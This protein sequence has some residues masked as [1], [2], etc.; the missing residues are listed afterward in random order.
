MYF[1][2]WVPKIECQSDFGFVPGDLQISLI[3]S[4]I[5]PDSERLVDYIPEQG[6]RDVEFHNIH[7]CI[8]IIGPPEPEVR[9][10]YYGPLRFTRNRE[11]RVIPRLQFNFID[12]NVPGKGDLRCFICAGTPDLIIG[13]ELSEDLPPM[14]MG[15]A[16]GN[17]EVGVFVMGSHHGKRTGSWFYGLLRKGANAQNKKAGEVKQFHDQSFKTKLRILVPF[18]TL[19][20]DPTRIR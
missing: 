16:V 15:L 11:D 10:E 5:N 13:N 7:L 19:R 8:V 17:F 12:S 18:F 2:A 3:I 6:H 4:L 14:F 9:I 20:D 1:I